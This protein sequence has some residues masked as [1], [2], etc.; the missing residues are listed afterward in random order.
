MFLVYNKYCNTVARVL[1]SSLSRKTASEWS[2][3]ADSGSF[4]TRPAPAFAAFAAQQET[5]NPTTTTTATFLA[6]RVDQQEEG[7]Q[8]CKCTL[9]CDLEK[10]TKSLWG[11]VVP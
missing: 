5:F 7:A 3:V 6:N 8:C 4:M 1:F 9:S 11:G 10:R 2:G